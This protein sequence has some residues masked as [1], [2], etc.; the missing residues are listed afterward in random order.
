MSDVPVAA[1]YSQRQ[2]PIIPLVYF[3][4]TNFRCSISQAVSSDQNA[5]LQTK[6]VDDMVSLPTLVDHPNANY[7]IMSICH[8]K[9][10]PTAVKGRPVNGRNNALITNY[11][12]LFKFF[13][14]VV[15]QDEIHSSFFRGMDIVWIFSISTSRAAMTA[16]FVSSFSWWFSIF[17]ILFFP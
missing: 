7:R 13:A 12:R 6:I 11:I 2:E 16:L 9:G 1:E 14:L 4:Q 5:F 3:D 8:S 17:K 10:T 15:L